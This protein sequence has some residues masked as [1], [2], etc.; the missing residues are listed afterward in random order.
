[1]RASPRRL[2]LVLSATV[3]CGLVLTSVAGATP[4]PGSGTRISWPVRVRA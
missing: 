1:M 2:V 3:I 4:Q